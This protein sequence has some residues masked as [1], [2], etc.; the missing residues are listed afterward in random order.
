MNFPYAILYPCIAF[1]WL[2]QS[3]LKDWLVLALVFYLIMGVW[4]PHESMM[5]A[6]FCEDLMSVCIAICFPKLISL[7]DLMSS[8][9]IVVFSNVMK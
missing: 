8:H 5:T 1:A 9:A 4:H 3:S 6:W 7:P 2:P